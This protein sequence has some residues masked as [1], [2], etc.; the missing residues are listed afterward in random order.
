VCWRGVARS[1]PNYAR[2]AVEAPPH[3]KSQADSEPA[4]AIAR[5]WWRRYGDPEL[6]QLI[7]TASAS[8]Q[9]LRQAVARVD[10]ARARPPV[11]GSHLYPT[12]SLDPTDT[13]LRTSANRE[14][15]ITGQR[16]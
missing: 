5:E 6:D 7:A 11:A 12:I 16:V 2:P 8:N 3:F 14:S 4:P 1:G 13:R 9:T 15:T 10:E